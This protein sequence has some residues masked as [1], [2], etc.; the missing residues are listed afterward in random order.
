[1]SSI[2][3][4]LSADIPQVEWAEINAAWGQTLLLLHTIARKLDYKFEKYVPF[5]DIPSH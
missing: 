4:H 5:S 3:G 1:M 2:L